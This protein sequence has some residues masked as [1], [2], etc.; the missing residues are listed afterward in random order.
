V[1][2]IIDGN[3]GKR[4]YWNLDFMDPKTGKH[5]GMT[6]HDGKIINKRYSQESGDILNI[7]NNSFDTPK[8]LKIATSQFKL[9][10][11][12]GWAGGYH[13]GIEKFENNTVLSVLG[14]DSNG[15]FA[16]VY[17]NINTGKVVNAERKKSIGGGL[18]IENSN[19]PLFYDKD[20][21]LAGG[22]ISPIF[23]EDKTIF[24]WGYHNI[25]NKLI[26]K[27]SRN[28]GTS[29]SNI[30]IPS[31]SVQKIHFSENYKN[32]NTIYIV[33]ENT[34]LKSDSNGFSWSE[35]LKTKSD[36]KNAFFRS[37]RISV[38]TD[39][40]ILLTE[41]S[42]KSWTT[43][44][45]PE[46]SYFTLINSLGN[47]LLVT[48][49]KI[50]ILKSGK[51]SVMTIPFGNLAGEPK[52]LNDKLMIYSINRIG[53][54]DETSSKWDVIKSSYPIENVWPIES[55][56]NTHSLYVLSKTGKLYRMNQGGDMHEIVNHSKGYIMHIF[57]SKEKGV[58]F[59]NTPEF[60]WEKW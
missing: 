2:K 55:T 14:R 16:K 43:N 18:F 4:R 52:I 23:I 48:D 53:I 60:I 51:W 58:F 38:L 46:E 34:I 41:N 24:I 33:T 20:L 12:K 17:F 25:S 15:N 39:K 10:P 47:F 22:A 19:K 57:G 59:V 30:T 45:L 9:N 40:N 1:K 49:Q 13:F 11:G 50:Y 5:M 27:V 36:I 42:G 6:I 37:N 31:N 7:P 35:V 29:W 44:I 26:I 28:G 32:D 8:A 3:N 54:F 56:D 21:S